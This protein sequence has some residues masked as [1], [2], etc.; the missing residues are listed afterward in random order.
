MTKLY[1]KWTK[2]SLNVWLLFLQSYLT[3]LI[4]H[5]LLYFAEPR[6]SRDRQTSTFNIE[7]SL[8]FAVMNMNKYYILTFV[9]PINFHSSAWNV[10]FP[11]KIIHILTWWCAGVRWRFGSIMETVFLTPFCIL[12]F[13]FFSFYTH[14]RT[15]VV[16]KRHADIFWFQL[17]VHIGEANV[18]I[19]TVIDTNTQVFLF[20]MLCERVSECQH[21]W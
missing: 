10:L 17:N 5:L 4:T 11:N 20:W 16:L 3:H 7:V 15:G 13:F 1:F 21:F 12:F 2:E 9:L 8:A 19:L 6:F 18:I 14:K